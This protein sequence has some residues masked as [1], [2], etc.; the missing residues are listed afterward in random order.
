MAK[1]DD[2]KWIGNKYG[3]LTVVE[4]VHVT[5]NNGGKQWYWKLKCDCGNET[6]MN[7]HAVIHGKYRSCGCSFKAGVTATHRESHT[8]LHNIW[9]GMNKRCN[10]KGK[11]S[12]GYGDRGISVCEEWKS[13]EAFS[14]WARENGYEEGLTI[15]RIDVN[16]NYCPQ[17]CTWIT[18]EKQA[19]NRRTTHWVEYQGKRMSLAEACEQAN[20]PYK[21]VFE[22]IV[23]RNWPVEKALS[24]PMRKMKKRSQWKTKKV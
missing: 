18:L 11:S 20:L 22:R 23:K 1:Y 7:P 14:K 9:C 2:N 15:E 8:P 17:N 13:Y 3:N 5:L 16:G 12:R 6:I 21:Q 19:R 24:T 4:P 10:P